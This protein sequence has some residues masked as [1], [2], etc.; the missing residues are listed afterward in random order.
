MGRGDEDILLEVSQGVLLEDDL[1][2]ATSGDI[3][4]LDRILTVSRVG[5]E[6][7]LNA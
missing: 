1:N 3:N 2:L 7:D 4:G 5:S 6:L